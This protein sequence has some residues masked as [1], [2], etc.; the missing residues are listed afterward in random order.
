MLWT[1]HFLLNSQAPSSCVMFPLVVSCQ[2]SPEVSTRRNTQRREWTTRP[3]GG[4][5]EAYRPFHL[6][7]PSPM[8]CCQK[9]SQPTDQCAFQT[10]KIHPSRGREVCRWENVCSLCVKLG[11]IGV[12]K[13]AVVLRVI[14]QGSGKMKI[15]VWPLGNLH[16]SFPCPKLFWTSQKHAMKTLNH[17]CPSGKWLLKSACP[18][19]KSAHPRLSK[20]TFVEHWYWGLG[21]KA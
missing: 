8:H 17:A 9:F 5:H 3:Q 7:H 11:H 19:G 12:G 10:P 15:L 6:L 13:G 20:T 4:N 2:L 18:M 16:F 14:L 1:N 21:N